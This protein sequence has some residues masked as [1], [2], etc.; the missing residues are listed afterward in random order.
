[1]R[2]PYDHAVRTSILSRYW[3]YKW[4]MLPN[5]ILDPKFFECVLK[6]FKNRTCEASQAY[7]DIISNI[8]LRHIGPIV[9]FVLCIPSWFPLKADLSQWLRFIARHGIKEFTLANYHVQS[10]KL[11]S[12]LYSFENL[13]VLELYNCHDLNLPPTFKGF[14]H[15]K[16]MDLDLRDAVLVG[17]L[18]EQTLENLISLCS[19][20]EHLKLNINASLTICAPNL[21]ELVVK[22]KLSSL[23]LKDTRKIKL[24]AMDV[25]LFEDDGL[26]R[27][28]NEFFGSL[29]S[30]QTLVLDK[31]FCLPMDRSFKECSGKSVQNKGNFTLPCLKYVVFNFKLMRS[32]EL[33]LIKLVLACSPA[34]EVMAIVLNELFFD[35][36]KLQVENELKRHGRASPTAGIIV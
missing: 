5:I 29:L 35:E 22:G 20:L 21:Q 13:R 19:R 23:S 12:C 2:L 16:V 17:P 18:E 1:M 33:E 25:E 28:M 6:R 3:R 4:V 14:P 27:S 8:L 31:E 10:P 24:L 36:E 15:L 26:K 11:S 32:V 7:S 9:K 34:L 30:C